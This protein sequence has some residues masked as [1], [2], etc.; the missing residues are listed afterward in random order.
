MNRNK[1]EIAIQIV[2]ENFKT[3]SIKASALFSELSDEQISNEVSPTK[4]SGHYLLGHLVAVHDNML[5]LLGLGESLYPEIVDIFI[6]NPDYFMAQKP[7]IAALRLQWEQLNKILWE[8]LESL[9]FDQWF[10]KYASVSEEDFANEPHR[11]KLNVVLSRSNH[12][13]YHVG[14][15]ALLKK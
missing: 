2:L 5:P 8:K 4:N 9:S 7:T 11:N 1:N 15:L 6:K 10:E 14:Q 12:L 13:A 3:N